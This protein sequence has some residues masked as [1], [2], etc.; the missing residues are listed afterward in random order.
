MKKVT[1][2]EAIFLGLIISQL[3]LMMFAI[4][5]LTGAIRPPKQMEGDYMRGSYKFDI[6]QEDMDLIYRVVMSEAGGDGV[7]S[8][9]GVATVILNRLFSPRYPDSIPELIDGQFSTAD[10]GEPTE[11]VRRS[12]NIA[13]IE[14]GTKRQI[15][16]YQCYYFRA[17][18]YHSFGIPYCQLGNNYFSLSEEAT[19]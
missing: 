15:L 5:F 19:D 10:N 13:I 7:L 6:S 18:D 1:P 9:K 17:W 4:R 8:Q 2:E 14:Y 11:Q 12:V 3:I 16:P